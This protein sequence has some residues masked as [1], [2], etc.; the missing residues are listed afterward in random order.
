MDYIYKNIKINESKDKK[1]TVE[2]YDEDTFNIINELMDDDFQLFQYKKY[3]SY[4]E[5]VNNF[6]KDKAAMNIKNKT[7]ATNIYKEF[8]ILN[9]N[10]DKIEK[11]D[12]EIAGFLENMFNG[13]EIM[14]RIDKTNLYFHDTKSH[15]LKLFK[16]KQEILNASKK[17][18]SVL[19]IET[20]MINNNNDMKKNKNKCEQCN[21]LSYN[22][23]ALHCHNISH[24]YSN[25][26]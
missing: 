19:E 2:Y 11:I 12:N 20:S 10:N 5:F 21:F 15:V 6:S 17:M 13:I 4:D 9:S 26:E 7:S 8:K 18:G 22:N 23:C 1:S 16:D 14:L 25:E 24:F 3:L